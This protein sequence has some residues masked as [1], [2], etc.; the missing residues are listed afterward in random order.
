MGCCCDGVPTGSWSRL[1]ETALATPG[2]QP[3][4]TVNFP[5]AVIQN[6][7]DQTSDEQVDTQLLIT[8]TDPHGAHNG[9]CG[10]SQH[11]GCHRLCSPL[12]T[13]SML[14]TNGTEVS[15]TALADPVV[16]NFTIDTEKLQEHLDRKTSAESMVE[17]LHC[18]FWDTTF[19]QYSSDGCVSLPNPAPPNSTLYWNEEAWEAIGVDDDSSIDLEDS[20][21]LQH[22]F[23]MEGCTERS[24][25]SSSSG[26]GNTSEDAA[27]SRQDD[28]DGGKYWGE[29]CVLLDAGNEAEC[30]WSEDH[31]G[32][33]GR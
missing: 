11:E 24:T 3:P 10:G 27:S 21:G 30:I 1:L 22:A 2:G 28:D 16:L 31:A 15:L 18:T 5:E 19:E 29:T 6:V 12:T 8:T 32:F 13:I 7:L 17:P 14:T 33:I 9:S 26:L 23:L 20:W 4:T 25:W